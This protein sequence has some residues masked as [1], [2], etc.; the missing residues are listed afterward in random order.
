MGSLTAGGGGGTIIPMKDCKYK[1][2]HPLEGV[3][4]PSEV[5]VWGLERLPRK[6]RSCMKKIQALNP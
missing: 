3:G 6:T 1:G 2:E 5:P 4:W